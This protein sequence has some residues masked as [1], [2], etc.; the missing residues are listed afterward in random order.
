VNEL[1]NGRAGYGREILASLGQELGSRF[2][3]GFDQSDLSRFQ[4]NGPI[5]GAAPAPAEPGQTLA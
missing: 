4:E 2:G 3:A 5:L 1:R